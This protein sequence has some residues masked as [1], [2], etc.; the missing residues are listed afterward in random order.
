MFEVGV[1]ERI[2]E[3]AGSGRKTGLRNVLT[4]RERRDVLR[5]TLRGELDL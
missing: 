1:T 3:P 4:E 5:G 2:R